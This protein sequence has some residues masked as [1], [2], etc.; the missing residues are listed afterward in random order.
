MQWYMIHIVFI[1]IKLFSDLSVL[2]GRI[3]ICRLFPQ[4]IMCACIMM[5]I[6][7]CLERLISYVIHNSAQHLSSICSK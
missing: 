4:I 3:F 6:S 2:Y 1:L 5:T 7:G